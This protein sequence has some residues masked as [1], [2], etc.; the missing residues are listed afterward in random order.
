MKARQNKEKSP[1]AAHRLLPLNRERQPTVTAGFSE[2]AWLGLRGYNAGG[3]TR[4]TVQLPERR[5]VM[6]EH[7]GTDM[8]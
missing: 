2:R 5:D 1:I 8:P 6:G 4:L 7:A 3:N